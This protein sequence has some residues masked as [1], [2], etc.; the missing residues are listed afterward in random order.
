MTGT[1]DDFSLTPE[2]LAGWLQR[3]EP[4]VV[5]DVRRQPAF[6]KD[7]V[8]IPGALRVPP[9]QVESWARQNRARVGANVVAYCVYGH[10][11]SQAAVAELAAHGFT[12]SYLAG[13][14]SGWQAQGR[15]TSRGDDPSTPRPR[16][17]VLVNI[18][19]DDL[20][21]AVRFYTAAFGFEV[22]RRFGAG[23]VE[24]QGGS[25]LIYLLRKPAGTEAA[26]GLSQ[27]RDYR[28]HWTPVHLDIVVPDVEAAVARALAAGAV[29]EKPTQ[30][31]SWGKLA[32]LADP[33][34]NGFC[35]LQFVGR[36]YDEI[37]TPGLPAATAPT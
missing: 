18:D 7:P 12:A 23:G 15:P 20:D 19:V 17:D 34:G 29:L 16:I 22:S 14:M 30:S 8:L 5:L 9:D 36:G 25:S 11:V 27:R 32:L 10:E 2:A 6:D 28:R 31:N 37:S 13:G 4:V 1:S 35:L 26:A 33:F 21:R 24:L 3:G